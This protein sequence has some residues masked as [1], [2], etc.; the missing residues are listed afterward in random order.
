VT[1]TG[2]SALRGVRALVEAGY[3]VEDVFSVVDRNEGGAA[4]IWLR[5]HSLFRKQDFSD[6]E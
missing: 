5:L 6:K 3:V 2:G 1:T 4:A